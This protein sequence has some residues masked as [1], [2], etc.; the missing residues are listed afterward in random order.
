MVFSSSKC[1]LPALVIWCRAFKHSLGAGLPVVRVFRQQAKSGPRALRETAGEIADRL[2]RGDSL[3]DALES[4]RDR[5]PPLFL[6]LVAVGERSGRL[7]D[8]FRELEDYYETALTVQRD[9]RR[10]MAWPVIQGVAAVM[11]IAALI[12]VLGIIGDSRGSKPLDP[13][14]LGLT[15]A[16]GAVTFLLIA[17]GLAGAVVFALK[18]AANNVAWRA[19]LEGLVR[20]VPGWGPAA[21]L[22]ALQRFCTALKM[23]HE[24]GL[25]ADEALR[26]SLRATS[27]AAFQRVEKAAA[28][29]VKRGGR[30]WDAL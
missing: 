13:L 4:E 20:G 28:A 24:A 26:Y 15:G 14:G 18:Q 23:T 3:E 29:A 17:A 10:Q 19:K 2:E 6:T 8:A 21:Q 12:F 27:N 7:E 5:F 30:P 1:P 9:F 16:S 25:S 11:I 22:S